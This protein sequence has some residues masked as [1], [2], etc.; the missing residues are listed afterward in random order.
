MALI[1]A[2]WA[3]GPVLVS[4]GCRGSYGEDGRESALLDAGTGQGASVTSEDGAFEG[5][6]PDDGAPRMTIAAVEQPEGESGTTSFTFTVRLS[7]PSDRVVT[8]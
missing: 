3:I 2:T 5:G 4:L 6:G 1:L 7:A 8:K